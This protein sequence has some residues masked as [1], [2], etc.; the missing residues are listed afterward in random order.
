MPDGEEETMFV[1]ACRM[2]MTKVFRR[3]MTWVLVGSMAL[4]V[5]GAYLAIYAVAQQALSDPEVSAGTV[6][7][8]RAMLCWPQALTA[9]LGLSGGA[10]LGGL[11][12]VILVGAMTAQEYSWRTAHLW[13]SRG[14][15]RPTYL[16][17]KYA[18]L[19]VAALVVMLTAVLV[20]TPLITWFTQQLTGSPGLAGLN[21]VEMGLSIVKTAYTILPYAGLTF[22]VAVVT[23]STAA[24]IA[25]GLAYA[26]VLENIVV[27]ILG[28][29]GGAWA[30][31]ARYAPANLASA[32]IQSSMRLV[33]VD[34]GSGVN[35]GLPDPWVAAAGISLYVVAFVGL[36][37]WAFRRQNLTG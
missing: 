15:P 10:G 21:L 1:N 13:L 27:Q 20:A 11:M 26:L 31:I 5:A 14:L 33:E 24:A 19:L 3:R 29:A 22:L 37:L 18:A 4:F 17:A 6:A 32:L 25:T 2:E 9:L 23:R 16:L 28:L 36:A 8:L 7:A 30:E 12:I 35:A 34:L